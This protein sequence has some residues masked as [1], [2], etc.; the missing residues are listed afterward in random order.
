MTKTFAEIAVNP[1][2][3]DVVREPR[4]VSFSVK[5]LNDAPL[6]RLHREFSALDGGPPPRKPA[7]P[8]K[9]QLVVSPD[10]GYGKSHLLGR[11]FA[12]LGRRATKVYLRPFQ[13][14]YKAWH[15]ILLL[16]IQ[17]LEQPD[18]ARRNA[19]RQIESLAIGTLAHVAADFIADLPG[20]KDADGAAAFLRKLGAEASLPDDKTRPWFEWLSG[21]ILDPRD[22][23]KLTARLHLRGIDLD[24]RE[25]AWLII[26]AAIALDERHGEGRRTAL[27]WLRAEPLE[28]D[29][30]EFLGLSA[31]DNEGRGDANA[32]EINDL[33]FRRL[34]GL[35]LLASYYRPFLFCFDQ[36]EF[37]ASDPAL[38]RTLGNCVDQL[39]VDLRNHLTVVTAN[40][41]N[42]V[43]EI[44]PRF[45]KPQQERLS[46]EIKLEG[47][48]IDG[49][50]ELILARLKEHDL[51]DEAIERFFADDWLETVFDP[52][53][54]LGVRAM[55]M[56]AAD[57]VRALADPE[58]TKAPPPPLDD[59]FRVQMNDVRS[60]QALLAYSPDALMW[61]VKDVGRGQPGVT[62]SR[63]A[64]RRYVTVEWAWPH[65][66]V[67]FAFEGG[68]HW[69]RWG[70]IAKEAQDLALAI[71]GRTVLTYVFRTPDLPKVPRPSWTSVNRMI[72]AA[73]QTGF[74]IV[75][76]TLD[77]VCALHAARE[78]Y[79]N[80][81]QGNIPYTGSETLAWLQARFA[82]ELKELAERPPAPPKPDPGGT[83]T[84]G[85]RHD[86]AGHRATGPHA[87]RSAP[88]RSTGTTPVQP[89]AAAN[90]HDGAPALAQALDPA[91]LRIVLD[92]VREQ[93]IV[94]I[95]AVLGR[96]G[97]ED[98]RD[99]LL[100]SVEAHPNL[101]AHPG[102]RTI[103]LQWRITP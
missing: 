38:I 39:Y 15:S 55:L 49:A 47:I 58:Q 73:E 102:P 88:G 98:L 57:R 4:E 46:P 6:S 91:R 99:P 8:K 68:D 27:K 26:L 81:L 48:R 24:G 51:G 64:H 84:G 2:E 23:G 83:Q 63:P 66:S 90:G 53:P 76:L 36:T 52:L 1:F 72:E 17:E 80:A 10:R 34:Q 31:A 7:S 85:A 12:R 61:F 35:C 70:S 75:E 79:S 16:T 54:E 22:I 69:H 100:R 28:A 95:T 21:R 44:L 60:K 33:S 11:L 94:D 71:P 30:I 18:E 67:F 103:F 42:W 97:R 92:T 37:Y 77:Q 56:R 20:Y 86:A 40:Q 19:P 13:D 45:A 25:Q 29:E 65:R 14:P 41:E 43:S 32:Q 3:D 82:P 59:L 87:E 78:L 9:A 89:A 50:R 101:K 93:R 5:G 96:L 74:A 62:V